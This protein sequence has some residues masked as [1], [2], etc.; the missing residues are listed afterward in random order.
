L[1]IAPVLNREPDGDDQTIQFALTEH[2]GVFDHTVWRRNFAN[3]VMPRELN[4]FEEIEGTRHLGAKDITDPATLTRGPNEILLTGTDFQ[5]ATTVATAAEPGAMI[6][7]TGLDS[8]GSL[9]EVY[10]QKTDGTYLTVKL[11]SGFAVTSPE[12]GFGSDTAAQ[13]ANTGV[14]TNQQTADGTRT[15]LHRAG[16]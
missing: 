14:I 3:A 12:Q 7:R 15:T 13:S 16:E 4:Q 1:Q 10:V 6:V 11:G 9:C 8:G 5:S 2:D